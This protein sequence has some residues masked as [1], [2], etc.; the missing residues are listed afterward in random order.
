MCRN[1]LKVTMKRNSFVCS[2]AWDRY[3]FSKQFPHFPASSP[4]YFDAYS[5]DQTKTMRIFIFFQNKEFRLY[6]PK[7]IINL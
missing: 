6:Q 5:V 1:L 7:L 2:N 3:F 4:R